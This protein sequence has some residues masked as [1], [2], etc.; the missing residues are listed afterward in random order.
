MPERP[1]EID[2]SIDLADVVHRLYLRYGDRGPDDYLA[3]KT[4]MRDMV[5]EH[6]LCS[7][8]EAEEVIDL[9][10]VEG[11]LAFTPDPLGPEPGQGIWTVN[12]MP[13]A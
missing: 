13:S 9:L 1:R 7:S 4:E 12:R 2:A 3:G 10:E 8:L 5:M 11:Y 6:L